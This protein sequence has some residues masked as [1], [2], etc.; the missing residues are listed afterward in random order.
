MSGNQERR[1]GRRS[2]DDEREKADENGLRHP[3]IVAILP[4]NYPQDGE[5]GGGF[6]RSPNF[7]FRPTGPPTHC[8][9]H[10]DEDFCN[11]SDRT[12][13]PASR[14]SAAAIFRVVVSSLALAPQDGNE[15]TIERIKSNNGLSHPT[16]RAGDSARG[17]CKEGFS[18]STFA[19]HLCRP[20]ALHG[21]GGSST[22]FSSHV[23]QAGASVSVPDRTRSQRRRRTPTSERRRCRPAARCRRLRCSSPNSRPAV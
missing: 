18:D 23:H 6:N 11:N 7:S 20:E 4:A 3:V 22:A 16:G 9:Q 14:F 5:S 17:V 1:S 10:A 8:H 19:A 2:A 15:T 12:T 13:L 21:L